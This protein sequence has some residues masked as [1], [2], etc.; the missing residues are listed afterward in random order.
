MFDLRGGAPLFQGKQGQHQHGLGEGG[1]CRGQWWMGV[2]TWGDTQVFLSV[3]STLFSWARISCLTCEPS[4]LPVSTSPG[5]IT[6][7]RFFTWGLRVK[8]VSLCFGGVE[9]MTRH[10]NPLICMPVLYVAIPRVLNPRYQDW[11]EYTAVN[12]RKMAQGLSGL[13]T[14]PDDPV[15]DPSL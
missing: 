9:L 6:N 2:E 11:D 8:L 3:L 5:G 13:A 7:L 4:D 15:P 1:R 10:A 12:Y 14:L